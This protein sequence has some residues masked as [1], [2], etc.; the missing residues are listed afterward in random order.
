MPG[1][2]RRGPMGAGP[3]TGGRRG[4]CAAPY[5]DYSGRFSFGYGGGRRTGYG[6]GFR[7]GFGARGRRAGWGPGMG[8]PVA[9]AYDPYAG[10]SHLDML[11]EEAQYMRDTLE[12]LNRQ[13]GDLEKAAST[14]TEQGEVNG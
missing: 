9:D 12:R 6:L 13:I 7:R 10:R 3:M 14:G 1:F 4:L 2:D 8:Y 11:K 5:A